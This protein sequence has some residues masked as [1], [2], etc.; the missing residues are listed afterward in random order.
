M[1]YFFLIIN[2]IF[3]FEFDLVIVIITIIFFTFPYHLNFVRN[4]MIAKIDFNFIIFIMVAINLNLLNYYSIAIS[5]LIKIIIINLTI[6]IIKLNFTKFPNYST[7]SDSLTN[8]IYFALKVIIA[9]IDYKAFIY[10]FI[11]HLIDPFTIIKVITKVVIIGVIKNFQFNSYFPITL[12]ASS[13]KIISL[14]LKN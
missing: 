10:S 4:A 7:Y 8:F 6:T 5:H 13:F 14:K 11:T 1:N 9:P 3:K 2:L 12:S